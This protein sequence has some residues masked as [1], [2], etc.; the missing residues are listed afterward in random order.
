MDWQNDILGAA[1][2]SAVFLGVL[3]VAELWMRWRG[4][5]P[6]HPRKLV[7]L[8]GGI[9]CLFFPVLI[10]SPWVVFVM[11]MAMSSLFA[12]GARKDFLTSLHS[13]DRK[14]HGSEYYPLAIFLV[15]LLA[16]EHLWLY[17]SS[18]LV[19]VVADAFAALIGGAYGRIHYEVEQEKRS[20]EGSLVFLLISFLAVLGPLLIMTELPGLNCLLAALLTSLLVTGFEAISLRGADNLFVPIGVCVVLHRIV[21]MPWGDLVLK[22][23]IL[24]ALFLGVG[25]LVWRTRHLN[26]G[27]ALVFIL[28]TYAASALANGYWALPPLVGLLLYLAVR[29]AAPPPAGYRTQVKIVVFVRLHAPPLLL[30]AFADATGDH[31]FLQGPYVVCYATMISFGVWVY[32]AWRGLVPHRMRLGA[33]GLSGAMFGTAVA[34]LPWVFQIVPL[35]ALLGV[36]G[37]CLLLGL[38]NDLTLQRGGRVEVNEFWTAPRFLLSCGAALAVMLLQWLEILPVWPG[39]LGDG[40]EG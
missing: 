11:A 31:A 13:V 14:T 10:A 23:L 36:T 37:I 29:L 39:L 38:L 40:I 8:A 24:L 12:L 1:L 22:N 16:H 17:I 34:V 3:G 4:P 7:H 21:E 6:E 2:L 32:L 30:L 25:L 18:I 19:L 26:F 5:N 35:I 20:L 27:A 33:A 15:F 9:A 28:F